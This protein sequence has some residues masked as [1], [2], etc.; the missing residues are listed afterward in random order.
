MTVE[1]KLNDVV[2]RLNKTC[3]ERKPDL[4]AEREERDREERLERRRLQEEEVWVHIRHGW[5]T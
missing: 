2:N 4:C 5:H 1:K 3:E